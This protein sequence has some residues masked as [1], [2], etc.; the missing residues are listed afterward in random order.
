[1]VGS[2]ALSAPLPV[3]SALGSLTG[4]STI[5]T[6]DYYGLSYLRVILIFPYLL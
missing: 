5:P 4:I 1:L 6:S 3:M 2:N